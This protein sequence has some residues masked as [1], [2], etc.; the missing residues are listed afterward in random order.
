MQR[1]F[2]SYNLILPPR[3]DFE[4]LAKLFVKMLAERYM[5]ADKILQA[6]KLLGITEEVAAQI[7][8]FTQMR[9]GLKQ[10]SPRY[11]RTPMQQAELH[12]YFIDAIEK[13]EDQLEEE[14]EKEKEEKK[15]KKK[16]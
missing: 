11:Y 14:Q 9:D 15:N 8:V 7:I 10:I 6:A 4:S 12:K 13:L 2:A 1:Q 5:S 16:K 3:L